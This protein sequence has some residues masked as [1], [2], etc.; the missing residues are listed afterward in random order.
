MLLLGLRVGTCAQAERG[1]PSGTFARP[2]S[3]SDS[4]PVFGVDAPC[5]I[6]RDRA[7]REDLLL[8]RASGRPGLFA[9][10]VI[11]GAGSVARPS[12]VSQA[13]DRTK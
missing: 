7:R 3:A 12:I 4:T 8:D 13:K 9:S 11:T 1:L 5:A 6:D 10:L 2:S